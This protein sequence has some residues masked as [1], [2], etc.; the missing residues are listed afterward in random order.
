M[1]IN[2]SLGQSEPGIYDNKRKTSQLS[3]LYET[4]RN[5]PRKLVLEGYFPEK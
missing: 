1:G 2:R 5:K 4:S 3:D